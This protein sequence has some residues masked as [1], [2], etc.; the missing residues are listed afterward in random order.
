M[1]ARYAYLL[2]SFLPALLLG[3]FNYVPVDVKAVPVGTPVRAHLSPTGTETFVN[4]TGLRR[5]T[6]QGTLVEKRDTSLV[7]LVRSVSGAQS[8]ASLDDLYQQVDVPRQD[9]AQIEHK[10]LNTTKTALMIA[11]G[12]VGAGAFLYY[13]LQGEPGTY[14]APPGPG[15]V[16]NIRVPF[17]MVRL[18]LPN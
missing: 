15:P 13:S 8:R 3:C 7:F 10:K 4:R 2:P 9:I 17:L 16:D 18:F 5:A 12:V 11:G 1:K 6:V 14:T